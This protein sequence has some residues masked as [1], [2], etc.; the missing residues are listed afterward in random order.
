[1]I[2]SILSRYDHPVRFV[3]ESTHTPKSGPN[4]ERVSSQSRET[5][6][7]P[8]P[9]TPLFSDGAIGRL[10]PGVSRFLVLTRSM[11]IYVCPPTPQTV[12]GFADKVIFLYLCASEGDGNAASLGSSRGSCDSENSD[13]RT[14][15][16]SSGDL[17]KKPESKNWGSAAGDVL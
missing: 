12:E 17:S 5:W 4:R 11:S 3:E 1:M 14:F 10:H 15:S 9:I 13:H 2:W 16:K 7:E 8:A 6:C